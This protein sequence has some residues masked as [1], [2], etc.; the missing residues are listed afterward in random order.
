MAD[1]PVSTKDLHQFTDR[2]SIEDEAI[3]WL[4]KLDSD[5]P[6]TV[7]QLRQLREW[8][9]RGPAHR[10]ALDRASSAW[11]DM[12]V[13]SALAV[14]LGRAGSGWLTSFSNAI[15]R[16]MKPRYAGV[17][18][19]VVLAFVALMF[20][21]QSE[22]PIP[23]GIDGGTHVTQIGEIRQLDLIDGSTVELNTNSILAIDL[24]AA[25]RAIYLTRG[26]AHFD[27]ASDADA[28]FVV[29][30]EFGTVEAVGTAFRV[31]VLSDEIEV[32]VTE[33]LVDIGAP[34]RP[35]KLDGT[36]NLSS[37][38]VV[39][40][41]DQ[42]NPNGN[43]LLGQLGAG[44]TTRFGGSLSESVEIQDLA[45][46]EVALQLSWREG[47]L[48]FAG[49]PLDEVVA[50]VSRYTE[51]DIVIVDETLKS[52]RIGGRFRIGE[53]SALLDV[54]ETSFGVEVIQAGPDRVELVN[55]A[56]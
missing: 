24:S 23:S 14:P 38:D 41:Q 9:A 18:A 29:Y 7:E 43:A 19:S 26:E 45:E 25:Q 33:G 8:V 16:V 32:T 50:E 13:L 35:V 39:R 11:N 17:A 34:F 4:I 1:R 21:T 5:E 51:I 56:S 30:T 37:W 6:T 3:A 44:Q 47:L 49:E 53:I 54:L 40:E 31:R 36:T 48:T 12:D 52:T 42:N 15:G 28:P 2:S 20:A 10:D 55:A 22:R 27:V 46:T